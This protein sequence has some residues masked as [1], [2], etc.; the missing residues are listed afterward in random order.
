MN[1]LEIKNLN[2]IYK[3]GVNALKNMSLEVK[4][5]DFFALLGPNGAGKSTTIGIIS[6][7]V[8]KTSG[9]VS[10]FGFD[11][12]KQ[13]VEA[14][15]QLGLVPQEF[16]FNPFE[17]VEQI[18]MNQAGY[19]GVERSVAKERA[20]KYLSQLDLWGKR[21]ERARNLSGGMKRRLMIARALMHEPKLLILDE[22]TAGVDIELRRSMWTF[23]R[24]INEQGV[25]IILTTHYLEEAEMLCRNIG[26]INHGELIENTTMKSLLSK[27]EAETFILDLSAP[28]ETVALEQVVWRLLDSTTLEIEINKGESLNHVFAQLSEQ[29]INVQS[30]RNKANRL[31]ELFVTLVAQAKEDKA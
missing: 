14:K 21:G 8:N 20:K 16:N 4:K 23:L 24:S 19:Y 5:G 27:L 18:V 11:L 13:K 15:N 10:I 2:K 25:T 7:L 29:G 28:I 26:I 6:S 9:S 12:D 31:E 17:T 1:A 22:P 3:G 30:M